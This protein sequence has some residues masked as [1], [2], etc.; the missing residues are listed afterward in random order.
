MDDDEFEL[1]IR[2]SGGDTTCS[3]QS[4]YASDGTGGGLSCVSYCISCNG[5]SYDSCYNT[6]DVACGG[7]THC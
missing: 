4:E 6:C 7:T 3:T 2:I 5:C 1:D